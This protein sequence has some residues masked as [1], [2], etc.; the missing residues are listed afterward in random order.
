MSKEFPL[1]DLE[2]PNSEL[3]TGALGAM[4]SMIHL[5]RMGSEYE[6][7]TTSAISERTTPERTSNKKES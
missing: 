2:D 3:R 7:T 1:V 4:L 6:Y 5:K